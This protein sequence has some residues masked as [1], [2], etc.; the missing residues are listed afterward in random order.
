MTAW[1][2]EKRCDCIWDIADSLK[3]RQ[4]KRRQPSNTDIKN[5]SSQTQIENNNK[6]DEA[7]L[8]NY[9]EPKR[10]TSVESD[11]ERYYVRESIIHLLKLLFELY[12]FFCFSLLM[13]IRMTNSTHLLIVRVK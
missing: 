4:M 13:M 11:D 5:T 12:S 7:Q 2:K 3:S 6:P 10:E 9:R 8:W 1:T